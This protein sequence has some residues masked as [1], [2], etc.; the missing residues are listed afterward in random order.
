MARW[1]S[2]LAGKSI[3]TSPSLPSASR[4]D[5]GKEE[6]QSHRGEPTIAIAC[7]QQMNERECDTLSRKDSPR[8]EIDVDAYAN[9]G[10]E[11]FSSRAMA[12]CVSEFPKHSRN[13]NRKLIRGSRKREPW[14]SSLRDEMKGR[15]PESSWPDKQIKP[16]WYSRLPQYTRFSSSLYRMYLLI[17]LSES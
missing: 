5:Q 7:S 13:F 9:V 15:D 16:T 8:I 14:R 17:P 10:V 4:I 6:P 3:S 11:G 12:V 1:V 2:S